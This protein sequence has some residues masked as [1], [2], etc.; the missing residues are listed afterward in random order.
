MGTSLLALCT[1]DLASVS[2][3]LH[4]R[5]LHL[6]HHN[7]GVHYFQLETQN[8]ENETELMQNYGN[9]YIHILYLPRS[10]FV[11]EPL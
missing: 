9:Y 8:T 10:L 3:I 4:V 2:P 7:A 5:T 6:M 1:N 11:L